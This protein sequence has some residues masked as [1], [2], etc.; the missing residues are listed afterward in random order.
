MVFTYAQIVM[1]TQEDLWEQREQAPEAALLTESKMFF[2]VQ[3]VRE[4]TPKE[5]SPG[6]SQPSLLPSS[7]SSSSEI[8]Q[9]GRMGFPS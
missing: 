2:N 1:Q 5:S 6:S 4:V 3:R 7:S 9:A 8:P